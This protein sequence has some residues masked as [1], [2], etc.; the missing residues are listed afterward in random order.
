MICNLCNKSINEKKDR[1]VA[2][3]DWSGK[4]QIREFWC[5]LSCFNKAMNRDLTALEKQAKDMLDRARPIFDQL[6]PKAD[7]MEEYDLK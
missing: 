7:K 6:L 1:Y 3:Q 2:V 5:H 4:K